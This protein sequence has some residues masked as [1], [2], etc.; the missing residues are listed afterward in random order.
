MPI[1]RRVLRQRQRLGAAGGLDGGERWGWGHFRRDKGAELSIENLMSY[2]RAWKGRK[3]EMR[4]KFKI[5]AIMEKGST[6]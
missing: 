3:R 4:S 1:K 5:L 6:W 2:K